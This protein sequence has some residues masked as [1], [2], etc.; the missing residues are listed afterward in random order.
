MSENVTQPTVTSGNRELLKGR[1]AL[2]T[3]SSRGIGRAI[4][5]A[6]GIAGASVSMGARNA[7]QLREAHR[8]LSLKGVNCHWQVCDVRKERDVQNLLASTEEVL[9]G[10]VSILVNNAGIYRTEPVEKHDLSVWK[11]VLETNL[12]G[13]LIASSLVV[14]GMIAYGWG[15]IVN[16]SS[17]SGLSG[18]SYGSAYAASK[19]G[20][21]G[22]TKSLALEVAKEA[23][24]VNAICPGW[25]KTEM[26]DS[27]LN[28]KSWLQL[29]G[30]SPSDSEEVARLSVPQMR[31]I[32]A[33]EIAGLTVYLASDAAKGITGQAINICGGM[34][35]T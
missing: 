8:S 13:A 28:C 5:E 24:T 6:L 34:S 30:Q 19:A 15:R 35:L 23:I 20:M 16:I 33:E 11:E 27:Q 10:P 1:I 9:D 17:I 12:T 31:F 22:L 21:I 25:V 26:A 2:V 7:P 4:A 29:T 18:E 3:G 14:A 32:E